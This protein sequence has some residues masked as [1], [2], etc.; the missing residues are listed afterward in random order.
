MKRDGYLKLVGEVRD[1]Q[2]VDASGR[3][4]GI[5]DDIEFEGE[6]GQTP[7]GEG[8]P[9]GAWRLRQAA[10]PLGQFDY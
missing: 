1:L 2:I 10:S 3:R 9:R 5:A 8:A 7:Q 4:C 6:V